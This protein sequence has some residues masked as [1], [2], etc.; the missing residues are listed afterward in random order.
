[1]R[2]RTESPDAI[3]KIESQREIQIR[4]AYPLPNAVYELSW[5]LVAN[6]YDDGNEVRGRGIARA[7]VLR[8][9]LAA[10]TPSTVPPRLLELLARFELISR[11][12][13]GVGAMNQKQAYNISLFVFDACPASLRHLAGNHLASDPRSKAVYAFGLG[14]VGRAFKS[15]EVAAFRRPSAPPAE[16]PWGYVLPDGNPIAVASDVPE[17]A[18]LAFPLAPAE[19]RDWPYAVLQ[20]STDDPRMLLKTT[21]TASDVSVEKLAGAAI[22]LTPDIEDILQVEFGD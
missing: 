5:S 20:L 8:G 6:R 4:I 17:S 22:A 14:T 13:L 2:W 19:A 7:Q 21:N 15:G 11:D 3:V 9:K 1:M 18:I 16:R 10:L 12:V